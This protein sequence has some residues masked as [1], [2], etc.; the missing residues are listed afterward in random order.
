[1]TT[2]LYKR[3]RPK[4]FKTMVGQE[5]AVKT[6]QGYI[7]AGNVPHAL[8]LSGNSG[9]GKT[10]AGRILK[11]ALEVSDMDFLELNAADTRGIDT[12]REIRSQM[13]ASCIGGKCRMWLIDECAK[14]SSDAQTALLKMLE[15]T[16]KH[17]YFVLATTHP[18]K[19]LPTIRNRCTHVAFKP[20][21]PAALKVLLARVCKKEGVTVSDAVFDAIIEAAD[22]SPRSALVHLD[23]AI[24]MPDEESQLASVSAPDSVRHAKELVDAMLFEKASWPKVSAIIKGMGDQEWESLRHYVLAVATSLLLNPKPNPRAANVIEAFGGNFYDS[25]KAGFV[26]SAF[27]VVCQR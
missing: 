8:L 18:D 11:T 14:L 27:S 4:S 24:R 5:S 21:P 6:L 15:D 20:V 16:P 23:K 17:V 22:G 3:Y 13:S 19:L 25:K 7:D 12:I 26:F 1:M 9:C 10:S 2:E